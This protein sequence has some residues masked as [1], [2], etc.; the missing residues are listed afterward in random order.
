MSQ[1]VSANS[2]TTGHLGLF[3]GQFLV[4]SIHL[5]NEKR[6]NC[7][8]TML[9]M[10]KLLAEYELLLDQRL[11]CKKKVREKLF[12]VK[13]MFGKKKILDEEYMRL[14]ALRRELEVRRFEH[15]QQLNEITTFKR[16]EICECI[17]S[18]FYAFVTFYHEGKFN[19][20]LLR[21]EVD[22]SAAL[23][24]RRK[25]FYSNKLKR[26]VVE[27]NRIAHSAL[28]INLASIFPHSSFAQLAS[29]PKTCNLSGYLRQPITESEP[30]SRIDLDKVKE[31]KRRW[32]VL[33][34]GSFYYLSETE[35]YAPKHIVNVLTCAAR[36]Y[37][38]DYD[39]I[40]ELISPTKTYL[41]Q[42]ESEFEL[43]AWC[44]VFAN[45][46]EYLLG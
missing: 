32:F 35:Y 16:L 24:K 39:Y 14:C 21:G 46:T 3:L 5:L 15:I 9:V 31:W 34:N 41:Y 33:E 23:F 17:A 36:P 30:K 2:V 6:D 43:K 22:H 10:D 29:N 4:E 42:C 7:K 18:C 45:S 11:K 19:V 8:R 26:A 38:T 20:N 37:A 13:N 12:Q 25:A 40:L 44:T 28:P 1:I 27:K